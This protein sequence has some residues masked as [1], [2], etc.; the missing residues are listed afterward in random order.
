MCGNPDMNT[1]YYKNSEIEYIAKELFALG[2]YHQNTQ[3][4]ILD[5]LQKLSL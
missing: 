3:G 1:R 5:E 4:R 2:K